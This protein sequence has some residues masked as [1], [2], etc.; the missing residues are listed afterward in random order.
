MRTH[1]CTELT[2]DLVGKTLVLAGW[3]ATRRDHG[4]VIFIDLRD[5]TG[6]AQVVMNPDNQEVFTIAE[7]L[8]TESVLSIEGVVKMRP[9]GMQNAALATGQ[10]EVIVG[11]LVVH[12]LAEPL[13]FQLEDTVREEVRLAH[14]YLDLRKPELQRN[15]RLRAR[16]VQYLRRFL[17]GFE[18]LEIETP[19][20]TRS[21]PEGAR[22]Y[23]VPS[24][25]Q[26]GSAF[27]LPQSPQLFKQLLMAGGMHRYYQVVRCF[28][29]EDLRADRQPEFTQLDLETSFWS[30]SEVMALAETMIR[31]LFAE[32]LGIALPKPFPMMDYADA[33][34]DYGTDRPDTRNPLKLIEVAEFFTDTDF[35][36]FKNAAIDPA[37]R[38][39][40][41]CV[42]K[43]ATLTRGQIDAY[44]AYV[45][46]FGAKGLAYIKVNDPT[47]LEGLQSPIVKF[48]PKAALKVV[49]AVGAAAGDIVFF[50]ADK[51]NIVNDAMSALR[52]KIASDLELTT[53]PW[54]PLWVIN[55]PLFERARDG[56]LQALHHPF[57]AP[58]HTL[59]ECQAAEDPATLTAQ[60][61][62]MVLNGFEIGGGSVRI[63]DYAM[64]MHMLSRLGM[65]TDKARAEFGFLLNALRYGAPPHAGMAFGVDRLVMLMAGASSIREVMAFP[66][67]QS[68][69][70]PLTNAPAPLDAA[71]WHDLGLRTAPRAAPSTA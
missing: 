15:L 39:A 16:T 55:F 65:D 3:V 41:L 71:Q 63:H 24:R 11:D 9:E 40:A 66:K 44:T 43:G 36:V 25:T 35:K 67:T 33:V 19:F 53:E 6:V 28:R 56:Q 59:A 21:T 8:R 69:A 48:F 5:H 37:S 26:P 70:C 50:G 45:G 52:V 51:T 23:V 57:T 49:Q 20:L 46:E 13:P 18:F 7:K 68:A 47:T 2:A 64:Q 62:D 34:R 30:Q 31:N 32:V 22:D 42:P 27:A 61:Y 54:A 58:Q 10:V 1:Y 14:R 17:E 60:A 4:G 12:N 38:I 29:D